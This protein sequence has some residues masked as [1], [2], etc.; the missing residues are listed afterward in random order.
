MELAQIESYNI[1]GQNIKETH[2]NAAQ[3]GLRSFDVLF[4]VLGLS[5]RNR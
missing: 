2:K 4:S 1:D 5:T 3:A